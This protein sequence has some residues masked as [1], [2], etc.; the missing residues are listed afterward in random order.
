[1]QASSLQVKKSKLHLNQ[2]TNSIS[3][4]QPDISSESH[5][6]INIFK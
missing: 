6:K 2:T 3:K 4:K 5:L 1:M